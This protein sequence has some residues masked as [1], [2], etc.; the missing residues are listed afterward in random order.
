MATAGL[1][2]L[3]LVAGTAGG[4]AALTSND[5]RVVTAVGRESPVVDLPAAQ[6]PLPSAAGETGLGDGAL[7][8]AQAEREADETRSAP[9]E[10]D[11]TATRSPRRATSPDRPRT[12]GGAGAPAAGTA[13]AAPAAAGA[14][15]APQVRTEQISETEAIPFRTTLVRDPSLPPGTREIK[16]AGVPGERLLRYEVTYTGN[17]E[18]SRR[19]LDSTVTRE[20]QD[21][22]VAFG[23]R[24]RGGGGQHSGGHGRHDRL[25]RHDRGRGHRECRLLG[26]CVRMG[27]GAVCTHGD[28]SDP[29]QE[30]IIDGDLSLLDPSDIDE[31]E[32]TLPCPGEDGEAARTGPDGKSGPE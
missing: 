2:V 15:A 8:H 21:R 16:T 28:K 12:G 11:R 5:T 19:L 22:V 32:L 23:N 3:A 18:T 7:G 6:V 27:R 30:S 10:A 20:P 25:D 1:G 13:G 24:G 4:I 29:R 9:G 14:P 17:R 31:L 26:S